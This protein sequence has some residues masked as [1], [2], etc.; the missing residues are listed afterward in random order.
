MK[1]ILDTNV[2]ISGIF[3]TGPPYKI[4]KAWRDGRIKLIISHEILEEYTEVSERISSKYDGIDIE[5]ILE[6]ILL[7]SEMGQTTDIDVSI[8][9]D[10]SDMKFISCAIASK[11][12]IIVSGDKHL[13]ALNSYKNIEII[14]PKDICT[15]YISD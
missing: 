13:L 12:K 11:V 5:R 9:K 8:C 6:L 3:F 10:A 7:K 4:L 2:L 15:K 14:S 1:I